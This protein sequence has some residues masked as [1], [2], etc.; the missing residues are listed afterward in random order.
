MFSL[1]RASNLNSALNN[2]RISTGR[3]VSSFDKREVKQISKRSWSKIALVSIGL[4]GSLFFAYYQLA[5]DNQ[6]KRRVRVH[7]ESVGRAVRSVKVGLQIV[8]DYKWNLYGLTKEDDGYAKIIKGCHSRSAE[9]LVKT[10]I[11]N[12]GMYVKLGQG[13]SMM[14]HILPKE[15]YLTLRKLQNEA[16]RSEGN[17]VNNLLN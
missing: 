7:I 8:T 9:V 11:A 15:F 14:N 3:N 12:G 6:E 5:L 17:D 4:P 2:F 10:C 1:K 16:L 13:L